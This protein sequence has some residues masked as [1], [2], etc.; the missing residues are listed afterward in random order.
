MCLST[1]RGCLS[2][3]KLVFSHDEVCVYIGDI[4]QSFF[5]SSEISSADWRVTGLPGGVSWAMLLIVYPCGWSETER[6]MSHWTVIPF[7]SYCSGVS[8]DKIAADGILSLRWTL[9]F[10]KTGNVEWHLCKDK[11]CTKTHP[12]EAVNSLLGL[13]KSFVWVFAVAHNF[14]L[15]WSDRSH[16]TF[17]KCFC[18]ACFLICHASWAVRGPQSFPQSLSC[19]LSSIPSPLPCFSLSGRPPL[20]WLCSPN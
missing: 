18:S 16:Y 4:Y 8:R 2:D 7:M 1:V 5:A 13:C 12:A 17:S 9:V 6:Q 19:L 10:D 3:L 15:K 20:P 11:E 14:L